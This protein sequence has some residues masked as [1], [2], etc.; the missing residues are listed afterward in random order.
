[1]AVLE[2]INR[3]I[4]LIFLI[5]YA[6]QLLY[7]PLVWLKKPPAHRA[8]R[9]NRYAV[10]ICARNEEAVIRDLLA[11]IGGQTYPA[12]QIT[13]FVMADNCTDGTA[14]AAQAAGAVVYQR[15]NPL[16]VGKGYALQSLLEQIHRDYPAGFDGYFIFDADN[17][18]A[19]DYIEQMNRTFSDGHPIV[20]SY[21]NSKNYGD[22]WITAGYALWF[23]RESRY[24]NQARHLLHTSCAVSGTGF[25]F[26]RQ[27]LEEMGG[28]PFY[29][30][31]E[32]IQFSVHHILQGHI[33]AFCPDAVLYDEQPS[34]FRQSWRQRTRW[35]KG[36]L[37]V[38]RQYGLHLLRGI[39]PGSFSCFDMSMSIMPAFIL[40]AW[41]LLNHLAQAL[42][43][44]Y[45]GDSPLPVV[46][47]LAGMLGGMYLTLFAIG[48]ITTLTEWRQIHTTTAKKLL[49]TLTFP[50]FL[51]TYI[52]ISLSAFFCKAEWKPIEHRV[53]AASLHHRRQEELLPF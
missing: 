37:Q 41:G 26:S 27:I 1:M 50:L 18:L 19:P 9:T 4:A 22:N 31:T 25:L 14:A 40:S 7:I 30:L 24:L 35:S 28:W 45:H 49:Y 5:C 47:S 10:L 11:S 46:W 6:Y 3:A 17:L 34:T 48:L 13:T 8:S 21:R 36:Y 52:P 23:L 32:D 16:Q 51:F 39:L 43:L 38:F 33:I 2:F 12:E 15:N 20:T 42:L 29:L 44:I 53:N